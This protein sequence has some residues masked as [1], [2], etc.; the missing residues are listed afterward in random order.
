MCVNK[1]DGHD[2][3]TNDKQKVALTI[4]HFIEV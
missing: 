1:V 2:L 3:I 4:L